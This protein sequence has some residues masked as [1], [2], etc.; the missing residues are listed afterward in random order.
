MDHTDE[1]KRLRSPASGRGIV[2]MGKAFGNKAFG[3]RA[4]AVS[5][6]ALSDVQSGT[7]ATR[8]FAAGAYRDRFFRQQVVDYFEHRWYR[9]AAPEF[10]ID[11]RLIYTHCRRADLQ[12]FLRNL[13]MLMI[14]L[15]AVAAPIFELLSDPKRYLEIFL[16]W[17]QNLG[18]GYLLAAAILFAERL[19]TEHYL[20]VKQF[21]KER[22]VNR[23]GPVLSDV[24][25]QNLVVYGGYTPFVGSGF[26]QGAW[27]F[28]VNLERTHEEYGKVA[29]AQPFETRNL[30]LFIRQRLDRLRDANLRYRDVLFADGRLIRENSSKLMQDGR[31]RRRIPA[32]VLDQYADDPAAGTRSYLCIHVGDWGGELV[33]SIYLRCKKHDSGLFVEATYYV[34]LPPKPTFFEIDEQDRQLRPGVILRLAASSLGQT[35]FVIPYAALQIATRLFAPISNLL[36]RRRILKTMKRNPRFNFGALTSIREIGAGHYYR[37]YFQE[38]DRERHVKTVEQ[39]VIDAIAEFLDAHNIDTSDL[40]NRRSALL[41]NGVIVSGGDF[42]ADNV[43]VGAFAKAA[44]AVGRT[45]GVGHAPAPKAP[46]Q[47]GGS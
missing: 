42:R 47:K 31:P 15:I 46:Q 35:P 23:S 7:G 30:L 6:P 43:A 32:D 18:Y 17:F 28:S 9:A 33:V 27:S 19:F 12:E 39:C 21:G 13:A 22:F 8:Y 20:I 41:N 3:A 44:M 2:V 11:E 38:L 29:R 40:Q 34:L 36:E 4:A 45:L 26:Q 16:E 25:S 14:V 10:G 24:E 5:R 1:S 37:V